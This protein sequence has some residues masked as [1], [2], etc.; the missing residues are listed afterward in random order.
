M[1][2]MYAEKVLQMLE[3]LGWS[4]D[5]SDALVEMAFAL[6]YDHAARAWKFLSDAGWGCQPGDMWEFEKAYTLVNRMRLHHEKQ[7]AELGLC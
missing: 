6:K 5:R 3:E 2:E 4:I 1:S 7:L